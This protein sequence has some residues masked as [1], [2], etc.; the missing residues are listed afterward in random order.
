MNINFRDINCKYRALAKCHPIGFTHYMTPMSIKLLFENIGVQYIIGSTVLEIGCGQGFLVNH[1]LCVGAKHVVGIDI[2]QQ[3]IDTIP[4]HAFDR[5][6]NNGQSVEFKVEEFPQIETK[7]NY[8]I[9]TMFIGNLDNVADLFSLFTSNNVLSIIAFMVPTRGFR[10]EIE[11]DMNKTCLQQNWTKID[12]PVFLS[13]S[14]ERRRTIILKK[15]PI[16]IDLTNSDT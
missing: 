10:G 15:N 8:T 14:N 11:E 13:G 6:L 4:I 9:A 2:T 16:I 5:Y 1:F 3:I 12:F 7:R